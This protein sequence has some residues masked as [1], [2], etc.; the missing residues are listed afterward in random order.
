MKW[1]VVKETRW[2]MVEARSEREALDN[3]RERGKEMRSSAMCMHADPI[4]IGDSTGDIEP[5]RAWDQA[6]ILGVDKI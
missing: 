3:R 1:F 2:I 6:K 5:F 4:E